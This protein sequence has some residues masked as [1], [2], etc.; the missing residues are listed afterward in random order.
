[1]KSL[2]K[3]CKEYNLHWYQCP[4]F[5]FLLLGLLAILI[6]IVGYS[7]AT[8]TLN[9]PL[10]AS[11]FITSIAGIL[12]ILDFII[13]KS[14]E[15]LALASKMKSDFLTIISHQIRTP[16][17]NIA[18]ALDFLEE[19]LKKGEL[20]YERA[21]E[22][23]Q[24]S[25]ESLHRAKILIDKLLTAAKIEDKK[26]VKLKP[27]EIKIEETL[28]KLINLHS[29][30]ALQKKIKVSLEIQEN[31][32][33]TIKTDKFHFENILDNLIENAIKYGESIAKIKVYK[34]DK[35]IVFEVS[36]DGKPIPEKEKGLIFK[37]FYR[38]KEALKTPGKGTGLGLF[39][40]KSTAEILGGKISFKST[41]KETTFKVSLPL[42]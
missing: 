26:L 38:G 24:T 10:L 20:S 36:N 42:K 9:D 1:M 7:L 5:I 34:K 6:I 29:S 16:L 18:F 23:L 27:Q 33:E 2:F 15:A 19:K 3:E 41:P 25:K 40:V 32:P 22:D 31:T 14:L 39:I 21:K 13:T 17:T 11:F 12:L 28:K 30:L 4:Q 37:K 35:E 8:K